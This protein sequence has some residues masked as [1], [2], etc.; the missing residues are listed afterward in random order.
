VYMKEFG[1]LL[2]QEGEES[3]KLAYKQRRRPCDVRVSF[4]LAPSC[5]DVG[6]QR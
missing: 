1:A 3:L 6:R 2:D 5:I 4:C